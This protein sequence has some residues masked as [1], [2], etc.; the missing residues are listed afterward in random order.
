MTADLRYSLCLLVGVAACGSDTGPAA[1]PEATAPIEA[2]PAFGVDLAPARFELIEDALGIDFVHTGGAD[3][4]KLLPETMGSGGCLFDADGD[5]DL[6]L[7]L[8]SGRG[9]EDAAPATPGRLYLREGDGFVDGTEQAGLAGFHVIGQGAIAADY[10]GDGDEDLFLTTLGP[11]LLLRNDGGRFTEVG[12][13]AGVAGSTWTDAAGALH[14]EW[15]TGA[16]FADL[17]GDGWLDLF[18]CNYLKWSLE[19]HVEVTLTGDVRGYPSPK[20][21]AGSSCR[22]YRNLGD[23]RFEDVTAASGVESDEHKALAVATLDVDG[24]GRLDLFLANDTQPNALLKNLG[25]M[26]FED[27]GRQAGVG[28]GAD[29]KVR[30]GM[31]VD[32]TTSG[33]EL[34][35]AVGNFSDEPISYFR[36]RSAER[37]FFSDDNRAAG[38]GQSSGPSL[39][40]DLAL[41]DAN[42][43]GHTDL[44]A[45]NGHLEPDIAL[46][47]A[48]TSWRQRPQLFLGG[49]PRGRLLD[50]SDEAGPAFAEELVGRSLVLG[51]LD[52]DGDVDVI[53]TQNDGPV[54]VWRNTGALPERA[55]RVDLQAGAPNHLAIGAEV[56]VTPA[57]EGLPTVTRWVRAGSG[58]LAQGETTLTFGLGEAASAV[59]E[60]RWPD[61]ARSTHADLAPGQTHL[62]RHPDLR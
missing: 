28:Y 22:L 3:G 23:G 45:L 44:L 31:G 41:F 32:A 6:D 43:D 24:D 10:D 46:A 19:N 20:L 21:Y 4:R 50:Q 26:R 34:A 51:D 57:A 61:G 29:G 5:G 42:L 49:G 25:G 17:D 1:P 48:S 53:A 35:I 54:R 16:T 56:T 59:V 15:S 37:V 40:F 38:L 8:A 39:T 2:H 52:G 13:A 7:Y 12:A 33:G 18:V 62:L 60:V 9:W 55:L 30:A 58:Y 36:S 14:P 11:N 47:S 27:V